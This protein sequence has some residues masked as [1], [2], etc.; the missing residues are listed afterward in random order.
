MPDP[1]H[2]VVYEKEPRK[3]MWWLW[4]VSGAVLMIASVLIP[5]GGFIGIAA[6]SL[7]QTGPT[8]TPPGQ[9]TVPVD[10]PGRMVIWIG[11]PDSSLQA[12]NTNEFDVTVTDPNGAA[13]TVSPSNLEYKN[14]TLDAELVG[15]R[16]FQAATAGNYTLDV[17]TVLPPGQSVIVTG[18]TTA[19]DAALGVGLLL[20]M[21]IGALAFFGGLAMLIITGIRHSNYRPQ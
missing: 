6:A 3:P 19:K 15:A 8:L 18:D 21:G 10:A 9:L 14:S 2:Q 7:S 13:V 4:Y 11:V 1:F 17:K 20:L 5:C 12:V 16:M